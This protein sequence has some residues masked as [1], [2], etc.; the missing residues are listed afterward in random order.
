[1][2]IISVFES[3][4]CL[5]LQVLALMLNIE[6]QTEIGFQSSLHLRS[7]KT[8]AGLLKLDLLEHLE[9]CFI[10]SK[11]HTEVCIRS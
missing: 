7:K 3:G 6:V 1:M 9:S 11:L 2:F 4:R 8:L 5:T 10:G